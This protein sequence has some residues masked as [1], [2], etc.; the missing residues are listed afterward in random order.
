M[1]FEVNTIPNY[2][3]SACKNNKHSYN[4]QIACLYE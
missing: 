2:N 4:R 1:G 3:F